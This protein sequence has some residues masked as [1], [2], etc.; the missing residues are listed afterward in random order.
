MIH[1]YE[2]QESS[3]LLSECVDVSC[4]PEISRNEPS[5]SSNR[6]VDVNL[7]GSQGHMARGISADFRHHVEF[8]SY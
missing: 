2:A 6:P 1:R 8:K 4:E 3:E 7:I 5:F